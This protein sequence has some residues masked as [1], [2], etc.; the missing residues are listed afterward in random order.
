MKFP[1][2]SAGNPT[3]GHLIKEWPGK[4]KFLN[5]ISRL[6]LTT[7]MHGEPN[8]SARLIG[9]SEDAELNSAI[10]LKGASCLWACS[11]NSFE[12]GKLRSGS[13]S[14]SRAARGQKSA[15]H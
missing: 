11:K 2:T 3:G 4:P 14:S 9:P 13:P 15:R 10:S 1:S 6:P 8:I 7:A 5:K 12:P